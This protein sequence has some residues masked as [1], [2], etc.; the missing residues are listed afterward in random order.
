MKHYLAA[1]FVTL[2][3][4]LPSPGAPPAVVT[5]RTPNG[6]N[7]PQVATDSSGT[8]H[9]IYFKASKGDRGDLFYVR[10]R[11]GGENFSSPIR[12]NSQPACAISARHSR[13]A[14]GR[15]G[16]AHVVWNGS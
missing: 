1:A 13:L 6:G 9:L 4:C 14:V 16:R 5:L 11:D 10:S 12:V 2:F 8:V 7:A 3:F 15:N